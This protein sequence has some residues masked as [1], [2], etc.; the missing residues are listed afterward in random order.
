[1]IIA[2]LEGRGYKISHREYELKGQLGQVM[3]HIDGIVTCP[4]GGAVKLLELKT[5]NTRRYKEMVKKGIPDY[6]MSQVQIYML[7]S[8]QIDDIGQVTETHYCILNKD[9][10]ELVELAIEYDDQLAQLRYDEIHHVIES[11]D[12]PPA[13]DDWRCNMCEYRDFCKF[14]DIPEIH[15]KTCANVSVVDGKFECAFGNKSCGRH[16]IHPAFMLSLGCEIQSA[17]SEALAIDYGDFVHGPE[18]Y[19]HPAKDTYTSLEYKALFEESK[20]D[21]D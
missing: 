21:D 8:G 15:C 14:G 4:D 17:N 16:L 11:E 6:Y 9:T 5:A 7:L 3:G 10:S 12:M 1:V 18:G 19:K 2:D 13:E 20:K